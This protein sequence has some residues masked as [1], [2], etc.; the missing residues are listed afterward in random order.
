VSGR[1]VRRACVLLLVL[2]LPLAAR[3]DDPAPADAPA[4]KVEGLELP[5]DQKVGP[6]EGFVTLT[7]KTEAKRVRWLVVCEKRVK[8]LELD[9]SVVVGVP[10][11]PTTVQVFAAALVKDDVTPFARTVLTV[12]GARPPPKPDPGPAPGPSPGPAPKP[13][14]GKLHVTVVLDY[15][16]ITPAQAAVANSASLRKA[17]ADDNAALRVYPTTSDVLTTRKLTPFVTRAGGAP[18]L[19][20]QDDA[21]VVRAAVTLPA[22]EAGVLAAVA[23]V[24]KGG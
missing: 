19:I 21:G 9:R 24:R 22:D 10:Q 1:A 14:A 3:G 15:D 23:R 17:L 8:F 7:A 6:D 5:A 2:V 12:E 16:R 4:N 11:G 18:A 13:A 20:V